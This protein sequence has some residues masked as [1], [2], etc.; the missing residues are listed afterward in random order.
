MEEIKLMIPCPAYGEE[1][2]VLR[3][4]DLISSCLAFAEV[5]GVFKHFSPPS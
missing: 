2:D 1:E 4:I 5:E 3:S